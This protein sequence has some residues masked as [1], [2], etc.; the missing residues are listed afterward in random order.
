MFTELVIFIE[1]EHEQ[2]G[3][4]NPIDRRA[5]NLAKLKTDQKIT[6]LI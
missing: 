4:A 5:S 1:V 6:T 2:V 3:Q